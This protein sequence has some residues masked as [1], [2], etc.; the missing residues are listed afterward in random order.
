MMPLDW[1]GVG[2]Q[3]KEMEEER[4]RHIKELTMCNTLRDNVLTELERKQG[5]SRSQYEWYKTTMDAES[6][7][8]H[9]Q[10]EELRIR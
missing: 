3:T 9:N 5:T 2:R 4:H 10:F 7:A 8:R 6:Q 1:P